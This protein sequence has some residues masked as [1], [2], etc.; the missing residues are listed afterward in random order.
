[1]IKRYALVRGNAISKER[2]A[3]Y[4]PGNYEVMYE[5]EFAGET[6]VVI[7]GRD[8]A[9]WTLDGYVI[10][11][12]ASGLWWADEIDLSHPVMKQVPDW[13]TKAKA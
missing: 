2:I 1:M 5:G 3:V 8:S 7:G 9:G 4:M 6:V 12:L 13:P 11:R 10:P